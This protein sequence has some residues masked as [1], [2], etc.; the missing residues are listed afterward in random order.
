M[1]ILQYTAGVLLVLAGLTVGLYIG[2]Q[3][4]IKK[5]ELEMIRGAFKKFNVTP[6]NIEAQFSEESKAFKEFLRRELE[7]D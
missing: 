5:M 1:I 2:E 4:G 3:R 6:P 7:E